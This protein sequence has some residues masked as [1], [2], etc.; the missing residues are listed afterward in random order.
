MI[1]PDTRFSSAFEVDNAK[2][3]TAAQ[4][5]KRFIWTPQYIRALT[6]K[7]HIFL[8]S[9]GSGK[10]AL[11][12]MLAHDH[13]SRSS[14]PRAEGIIKGRQFIGTYIKTRVDW[15]GILSSSLDNDPHLAEEFRWRLN[16]AA[17]QA[18]MGTIKS[19]LNCYIRDDIERAKTSS[20]IAG[21]L[22][23]DWLDEDC[24][25]LS[26]LEARLEDVEY[27]KAKR[28]L[29]TQYTEELIADN[30]GYLFDGEW[31]MPLRRGITVLKRHIRI[32]DECAW[33]L[34]IDEAEYL[35]V[36]HHRLLNSLLRVGEGLTF[37]VTTMPYCHYTTE[38]TGG[39]PVVEGQDFDYVYIDKIYGATGQEYFD[40]IKNF[41][42]EL[43][44]RRNVDT[45]L[46]NTGITLSN[47][48]GH[49]S[50][51]REESSDWS[52]DSKLWWL[53]QKHANPETKKRAE[54]L[55]GKAFGEQIGRKLAAALK[56]REEVSTRKG[57]Q[58][59][60]AYSGIDIVTRCSDGN[61]RRLLAIL[62]LIVRNASSTN[63]GFRPVA[64]R[65]QTH[66]L[67]SVAAL[68]LARLKESHPGGPFAY[69]LVTTAGAYFSFRL[70]N[71]LL[72]TDQFQSLLVR[73]PSEEQWKAIK[74]AVGRGLLFPKEAPHHGDQ[75]PS[76]PVELRLANVLTPYFKLLPR[77]GRAVSLEKTLSG[78]L[79]LGVSSVTGE[80]LEIF[81]EN[82]RD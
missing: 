80:Q 52:R 39:V 16:L 36:N 32:P 68:E 77:H 17:C 7:N 59:L 76:P 49:S 3:E 57:N 70:H 6:A 63:V 8:G 74:A 75:P 43:F 9:R 35:S 50:L 10:T 26:Q 71:S 34:C 15:S 5:A 72:S 20:A 25:S 53:L 67:R 19:C 29:R 55:H 81:R 28:R 64:P 47:V 82:G 44:D 23:A 46:E 66:I 56:L 12:K 21:C 73:H 14:D 54:T 61:P 2:Q 78:A 62:N 48:I 45:R 37:K 27:E 30:I 31:F 41:A 42:V 1:S 79:K 40:S 51:L 4:L 24:C 18:F 33:V 60:E 65:D 69:E 13:L 22:G 38:T 58:A 11:I